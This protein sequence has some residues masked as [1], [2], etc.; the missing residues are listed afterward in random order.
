MTRIQVPSVSSL[1]LYAG[2]PNPSPW[3]NTGP[4][5]ASN[6]AA[7]TRQAPSAGWRQHMKSLPFRSLHGTGLCDQKVGNRCFTAPILLAYNTKDK[8]KPFSISKNSLFIYFFKK[9]IIQCFLE[10]KAF[11]PKYL[12]SFWFVLLSF[13]CSARKYFY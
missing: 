9:H 2:V 11:F 12:L 8:K 7:E 1:K 4:W 13:W 10:D 5:H 3:T 6:R